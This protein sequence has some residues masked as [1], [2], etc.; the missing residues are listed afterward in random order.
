MKFTDAVSIAGTRRRED[1][2]LVAD[3]RVAR[4]GIQLYAGY[5]VG[6]PEMAVVRVY[7]PD[8]E[9]F[10]RD[11]LASFAHRPVTNDHPDEPVTADNWKDHAVG[12]TSDEIARDGAFVRVPLMV[13]DAAAI[14]DVEK[15]KRELSAGY[16]AELVWGDGVT[17]DGEPF[18]AM[19]TK[20]RANHVAIVQRGRAGSEVRIGDDAG[21]WGASPVTPTADRKGSPMADNLRKV[22]VDGLPVETTDAGETAILKLTK[23]RDDA[24]KALADAE[25]AHKAAIA[26]K[27]AELAKKDAALDAEKA[28]VLDAA[29]LDKLVQAR[30]DLIATAKAIAADVKTDGLSDAEIR[31]A[32]VTAKL[33]DAAVKDKAQ[34]YIDA[35]FD[36]LAEDAAKNIDPVRR[37][38]QSQD[39]APLTN[40]NGQAA[41]EKRL[42]DA[43]KTKKEA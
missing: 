24:R 4:T 27:D 25:T 41:Y 42:S 5:E 32:V 30:G 35:R 18:D 21:K 26:A 34:A 36:I 10:S 3:A 19:Q 7:R 39:R 43:W 16:S 17:P 15:G 12:N 38:L 2:Y 23:D 22:M 9:V 1:G 37:A 11:T 29:A 6:K 14:A 33:G 28:K 13:A 8:A 31:K 40:D 20:I